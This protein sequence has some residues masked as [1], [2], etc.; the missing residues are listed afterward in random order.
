M[1]EIR[2]DAKTQRAAVEQIREAMARG[3]V[4]GALLA[5]PMTGSIAAAA[6]IVLCAHMDELGE[7]VDRLARAVEGLEE[8]RR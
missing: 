4:A 8:G 7:K 6:A 3:A 1:D 2:F 5:A